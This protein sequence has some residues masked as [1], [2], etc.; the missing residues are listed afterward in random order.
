MPGARDRL[1]AAREFAFLHLCVCVCVCVIHHLQFCTTVK[2]H[3]RGGLIQPTKVPT[4]AEKTSYYLLPSNAP[5]MSAEVFPDPDLSSLHISGGTRTDIYS[6]VVLLVP[7]LLS[8]TFM[9]ELFCV[10]CIV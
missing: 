5:R 2:D 9:F 8:I 6:L 10:H 7:N 3:N 4:G 1:A